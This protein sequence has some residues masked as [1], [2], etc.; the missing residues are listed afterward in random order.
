MTRTDIDNYQRSSVERATRLTPYARSEIARIDIETA[1]L[2]KRIDRN[3]ELRREIIH[4]AN[5]N[6]GQPA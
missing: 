5:M 3:N 1:D 6:K 4:R 2:Q